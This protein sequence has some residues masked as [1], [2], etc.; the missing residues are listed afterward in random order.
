MGI[1]HRRFHVLVPEQFLHRA[2]IVAVFQE[3]GGE[4]M[5][6]GMATGRLVN[7]RQLGRL[8]DGSL[9]A[10]LA[11]VMAAYNAGAGV[12][13]E[14]PGGE[15]VLPAP[16]FVSVRVLAFEGVREIDRTIAV[17]QV[18][19]VKHSDALQMFLE[20]GAKALREHRHAVYLSFTVAHGDA[21]TGSAQVWQ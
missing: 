18:V 10:G 20:G 15:D 4:A 2:D 8:S 9:R 19:L 17:V 21:S 11:E 1:N 13:R 6:E 14:A 7:A 12:S 5:A 3:V 16:L